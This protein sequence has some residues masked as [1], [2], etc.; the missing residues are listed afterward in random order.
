MP[1]I[2]LSDIKFGTHRHGLTIPVEV[3]LLEGFPCEVIAPIEIEA[4]SV[5]HQARSFLLTSAVQTEVKQECRRCLRPMANTLRAQFT[6]TCHIG[7]EPAVEQGDWD[8]EDVVVLSPEAEEIELG[9]AIRELLFLEL[10][11]YP[12]CQEGCAGLCP[13]CGVNRNETLCQC[14]EEEADPRWAPLAALRDR[15]QGSS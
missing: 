14:E 2:S 6:L 13:R 12:L 7:S 9:G 15:L 8:P 4:T 3:P 11:A 10:S 1:A 5:R